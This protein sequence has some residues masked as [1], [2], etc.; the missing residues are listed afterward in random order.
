MNNNQ[1][2]NFYKDGYNVKEL[3]ITLN[4]AGSCLNGIRYKEEKNGYSFT[5]NGKRLNVL[6]TPH[7]HDYGF[8]VSKSKDGSN[9]LWLGEKQVKMYG[10][11]KDKINSF[12]GK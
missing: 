5:K 3:K 4:Q 2:K 9:T 1:C 11:I 6:F 8:N 10:S 7:K 12:F